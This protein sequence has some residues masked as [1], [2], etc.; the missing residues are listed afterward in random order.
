MSS[1]TYWRAWTNI[2]EKELWRN[3]IETGMMRVRETHQEFTFQEFI[4]QG[5]IFYD[6][7]LSRTSWFDK[8]FVDVYLVER[9]ATDGEDT[10]P[11]SD[12]F[13]EGM[14]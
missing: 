11:A 9:L 7:E 6:S 1:D 10:F 2:L 13:I 5:D 14:E 3:G 4:D 12:G 8:W